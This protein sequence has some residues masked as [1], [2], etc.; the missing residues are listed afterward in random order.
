V[1]AIALA[2]VGVVNLTFASSEFPWIALTLAITFSVYGLVRKTVNAD[3]LTALFVETML[4][5]PLS[6]GYIVYAQ[7][8]GSGAVGSG[9][10]D[11]LGM[12]ML[13]GPITAIPLLAF[14]AA[15]RRLRYSTLGILQYLAPTMQFLVA[16]FLFAENFTPATL[17]SFVCIWLA[18]G[19]YTVD[20]LR[21]YHSRASLGPAA[22]ARARA[23]SKRQPVTAE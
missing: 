19:I 21:A 23:T 20:S 17:A 22:K 15:A 4:V 14:A 11:T 7:S 16:V 6:L 5:A 18:I 1:A 3:S 12:L 13:S 10:V 9:A 2:M 8:T